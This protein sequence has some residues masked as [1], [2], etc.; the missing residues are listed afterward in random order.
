MLSL[1]GLVSLR[2][3]DKFANALLELINFAT[4]LVDA[5]HDVVIHLAEARLH[6]R[7]HGLHEFG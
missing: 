2:L 1:A 4:H 3:V 5:P 6:L 7:E